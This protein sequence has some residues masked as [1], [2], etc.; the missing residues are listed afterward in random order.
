[1]LWSDGKDKIPGEVMRRAL[2]T[3]GEKMTPE[4]A[5]EFMEITYDGKVFMRHGCSLSL[6]DPIDTVGRQD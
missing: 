4:E 3:L 6:P 1:M 2:T 5:E